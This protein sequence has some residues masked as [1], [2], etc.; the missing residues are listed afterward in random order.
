M[1][2][3][4]E[5][6]TGAVSVYDGSR[7]W[8][9]SL[10]SRDNEADYTASEVQNCSTTHT[11]D[12][13]KL[14]APGSVAK[15]SSDKQD[16]RDADID[17]T[18]TSEPHRGD[19]LPPSVDITSLTPM[20]LDPSAI[21]DPLPAIVHAGHPVLRQSAASVPPQDITT[22]KMHRLVHTMVEVMRRASG[23][24]LAAPQIGIGLRV[25]M[26]EDSTVHPAKDDHTKLKSTPADPRQWDGVPFVV[27][28]NPCIHKESGEKVAHFEGCLSV[29]GYSAEV[30]RDTKVRVSGLGI[31]GLPLHLLAH[32]WAARIFQHECD[33]LDGTLYV[34]KM[35]PRSLRADSWTLSAC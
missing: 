19:I 17:H 11:D 33:H 8:R 7:E 30:A 1:P 13:E 28:F 2:S 34:D 4:A 27:V 35:D 18:S 9:N 24:G 14:I 3:P 12:H 10:H 6:S 15:R 31:D 23:V 26:V 22:E 16:I 32:G 20:L 29:P 5:A 25:I 21:D